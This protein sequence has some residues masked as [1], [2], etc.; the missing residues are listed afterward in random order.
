MLDKSTAPAGTT[1]AWVDFDGKLLKWLQLKDGVY[2]FW[3]GDVLA[4]IQTEQMQ[5]HGTIIEV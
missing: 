1:H 2:R 3:N 5:G 4:A